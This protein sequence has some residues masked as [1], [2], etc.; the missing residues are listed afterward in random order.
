MGNILVSEKNSPGLQT[1]PEFS[2]GGQ[3]LLKT[4]QSANPARFRIKREIFS[5]VLHR[6]VQLHLQDFIR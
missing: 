5:N 2:A 6:Q 4:D 1:Y 3:L